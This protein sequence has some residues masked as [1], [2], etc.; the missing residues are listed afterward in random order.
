[1][2]VK[3]CDNC[4]ICC[5]HMRTPPFLPLHKDEWWKCLPQRL[6]DEVKAHAT[7]KTLISRQLDELGMR[8]DAPCLWFD[9][10]SGRCREWKWRPDICREFEAGGESCL[11][12]RQRVR[13]PR[14][15]DG[16]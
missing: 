9:M 8:E 11:K 14:P 1:M 2:S 13:Q 4:G 3:N 15:G 10:R 16:D 7:R 5:C 12:Y 6:Q